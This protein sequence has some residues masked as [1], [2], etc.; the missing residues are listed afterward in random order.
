MSGNKMKKNSCL[1][2]FLFLS[3][4]IQSQTTLKGTVKDTLNNKISNVNV[5]LK[6]EFDAS[7]IAF[8]TTAENGNYKIIH[9]EAGKYELYFTSL[10][11]ET[12]IIPIEISASKPLIIKNIVLKPNILELKEV[13]ISTEKSITVKKDTIVYKVA[14]FNKGDESVVED[15][16]K[17]LPGIT[18]ES[19]G[20]VKFGNKEVEKIMIEGD[21][22]FEKRYKLLSK[23]MPS[24]TIDKVE[25]IQ[26]YS[27]NKLL[28][29][30]EGSDK[31]ALNLKLIENF[32]S[33]WFGNVFGANNFSPKNNR[34]QVNLN[35][36]N[37]GKKNKYYFLSNFNNVGQDFNT[38]SEAHNTD[39]NS[40]VID[41]LIATQN[42]T[43]DLN[44]KRYNFNNQKL[45]SLN[46]ITTLSE[47]IKLKTNAYLFADDIFFSKSRI[48]TVQVNTI[49][50][51]NVENFNSFRKVISGNAKI[52][53]N[54]DVSK[55]SMLETSTNFNFKNL[56]NSTT[57]NFNSESLNET[58]DQKSVFFNQNGSFTQKINEKSALILSSLLYKDNA[59]ELFF[60]SP[61]IYNV[62][63][64]Q[65]AKATRQ[66]VNRSS[67][68]NF[69]EGKYILKQDNENLLELSIGNDFKSTKY[70][71]KFSLLNDTEVQFPI[72]F[73]NDL[74]YDNNNF[75]LK[76]KYV[77]SFKKI[78]FS[79]A[80][81]LNNFSIGFKDVATNSNQ[82]LLLIN[83]NF[84]T[85]FKFSEK[86]AVDMSFSYNA[87]NT[88]AVDVLPNYYNKQF[89]NFTKGLNTIDRLDNLAVTINH[90]YGSYIDQFSLNSIFLYTKEFDFFSTNS[91]VSQ[92][93]ILS[94]RNI[95]KNRESFIFFSSANQFIK[96]LSSNLK[97]NISGYIINNRNKISNLER[98]F[99]STSLN[100]GLEFRTAFKGKFQFNLGSKWT[101]N[102]IDTGPNTSFTDNTTFIDC[103]YAFNKKMNFKIQTERNFLGNLSAD[104]NQ[105]YFVDFEFRYIIKDSKFS[106]SVI[107][108]NLLNTT[109]FRNF[110]QTDISN[111]NTQFQLQPRF[112]L[113]KIEFRLP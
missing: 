14:S 38:P 23:N 76:S 45:L 94:E 110:V 52:D 22:F 49:D 50:F 107:G 66:Q 112:G 73:Q 51:Q 90:L 8:T 27:E 72:H 67:F 55:K 53:L 92:N 7:L 59:N 96:P 29:N 98:S 84:G 32:K 1:F 33:Q 64:E 57:T 103:M 88:E 30:I 20:T 54:I 108:N 75:Y 31:V 77:F 89:R 70:Q 63:F 5:F 17:N 6:L 82:N 101:Y 13:I 46:S 87:K 109:V 39:H 12:T 91:F 40:I 15:I 105:Y 36:I 86:N 16:L 85:S 71:T 44:L 34:H 48:E 47:K 106:V 99:T 19:N 80:L 60:T 95:L 104:F 100:Y 69:F 68:Y 93:T 24:F 97:L 102:L 4:F 21:D 81:S 37:I 56:D 111:V 28:K 83:S 62:V 11:F 43:P 65:D 26:K 3:Q 2:I 79:M 10:N 61:F 42:Q 41:P 18:V 113:L 25:V 78:A 74:S 58:V 35:L 9:S